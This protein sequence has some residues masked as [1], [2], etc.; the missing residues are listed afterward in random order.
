MNRSQ[1]ATKLLRILLTAV[2]L[3]LILLIILL[4]L[5]SVLPGFI[6]ILEHG[7]RREIMEYIRSFGSVRGV[8]LGFLLQFIQILSV[9]F[10]GAPIQLS[11]GVVFRD[12]AWACN[13]RHRL[14]FC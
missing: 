7:D 10:P 14:C 11:M 12:V 1:L 5:Q 2:A 3:T 6:D 4:I 8:V 9:I 13:M